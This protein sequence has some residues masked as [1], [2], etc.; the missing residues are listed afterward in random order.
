MKTSKAKIAASNRYNKANTKIYCFRFNKKTDAD[1][2]EI[3]EKQK[4]KQGFI[5]SLIRCAECKKE[6]G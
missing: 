6:R 3:L 4:S 2:I 1:I 5:K